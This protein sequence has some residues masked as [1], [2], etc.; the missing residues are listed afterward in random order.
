MIVGMDESRR[1]LLKKGAIVT[2]AAWV[3]P[4]L[5]SKPAFAQTTGSEA[6]GTTTT[7]T[8]QQP[9]CTVP[10]VMMS[11]AQEVPPNASGGI[12]DANV[13]FDETTNQLCVRITF[14]FLTSNAIAAHVHG[15]APAGVNAP[16]LFPFSNVPSAT[17]GMIGPQCFTLTAQ[18]RDE[19]CS[20]QYYLNVHTVNFPGG[21]IRGQ[22]VP[23]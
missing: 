5:I 12:A 18:Q 23:D 22:M 16:V 15:P 6:P 21:E 13:D 19:L 2:G 20:G 3:A 7:T 14:D 9:T 10:T 11:A 8:V 17:S 4:V 1:D